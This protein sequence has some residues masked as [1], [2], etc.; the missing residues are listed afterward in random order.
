MALGSASSSI[1]FVEALPDL[2]RDALSQVDLPCL[3][4]L[5]ENDRLE[6]RRSGS[7]AH[8]GGIVTGCDLKLIFTCDELSEHESPE[9]V[10][11][12]SLPI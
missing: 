2:G 6:L 10:V 5:D 9:R 11:V 8:P 4:L 12:F 3:V 1:H 7:G